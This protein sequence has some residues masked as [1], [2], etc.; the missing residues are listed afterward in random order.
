M[1]FRSRSLGDLASNRCLIA[2][3]RL[4]SLHLMDS[5]RPRDGSRQSRD[6][7]VTLSPL[8]S[9]ERGRENFSSE[10]LSLSLF[11]AHS[12]E[13]IPVTIPNTEVKLSR[14]DYTATAGN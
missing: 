10:K 14:A 1:N 5:N 3:S 4:K 9:F 13:E 7:C 6:M 11:G 12:A 2:P 8:D